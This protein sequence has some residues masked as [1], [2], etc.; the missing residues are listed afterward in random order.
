MAQVRTF[1]LA[2]RPV[3]AP[4]RDGAVGA[5][6]PHINTRMPSQATRFRLL[7]STLKGRV[8]FPRCPSGSVSRLALALSRGLWQYTSSAC[9]SG[10]AEVALEDAGADSTDGGTD[11]QR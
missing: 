11:P 7:I 3:S 4:S 10:H 6:H 1:G 5:P 8:C 9:P 2:D